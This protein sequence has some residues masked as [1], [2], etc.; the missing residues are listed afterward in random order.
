MT[1]ILHEYP[2]IKLRCS[3]CRSDRIE[4]QETKTH[5]IYECI[6]CGAMSPAVRKER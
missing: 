5:Y 6:D 4:M 2:E 1:N 3:K